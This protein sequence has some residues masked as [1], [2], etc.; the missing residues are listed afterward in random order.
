MRHQQQKKEY[1]KK[2]LKQANA[3]ANLVRS[4]SKIREGSRN[5]TRKTMEKR[6]CNLEKKRQECHLSQTNYMSADA[7]NGILAIVKKIT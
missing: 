3:S 2:K 4:K 1:K 6:I 5:G 7:V